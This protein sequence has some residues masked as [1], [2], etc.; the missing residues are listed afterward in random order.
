[1]DLPTFLSEDVPVC[2]YSWELCFP[3]PRGLFFIIPEYCLQSLNRNDPF[4]PPQMSSATSVSTPLQF[5]LP[6]LLA[7]FPW[8]RNLSE[9]FCEAKAESSAW[10]ESYH[11]FDEEGLKG[12]NLCDFSE[13]DLSYLSKSYPQRSFIYR[14]PGLLSV[15]S[16]RERQAA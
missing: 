11:P 7:N 2:P 16:S 15:F 12:F 4:P 10:T 13:P 5:T 1:M 6:D 14:S 3:K 9:Y 8:P